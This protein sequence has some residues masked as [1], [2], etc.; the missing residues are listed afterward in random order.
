MSDLVAKARLFAIAAHE[1]CGQTRKYTGEPY[2]LHP[3]NVSRIV[4][5]V[6]DRSE[7][8]VCAAWLHDVLEDTQVRPVVIQTEFGT[9]VLALVRWLTD[10]SKPEDGNRATRKAIDRQHIA[11]APRDAK[12]IKLADLLDN[13]ATICDRAPGFAKIY[14]AEKR[15]LLDEALWDGDTTLWNACDEIVRRGLAA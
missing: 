8:M 11:G 9:E 14:L 15:L 13:S 5:Q 12:T 4:S 1:A 10:A 7:A 2:W 3:E 6:R